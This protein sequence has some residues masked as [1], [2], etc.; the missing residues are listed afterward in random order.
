MKKFILLSVCMISLLSCEKEKNTNDLAS[1]LIISVD[2]AT[3]I[4]YYDARLHGELK[5]LG[6]TEVYDYGLVW[7]E[8]AEPKTEGP[9][10]VYF[11]PATGD[12]T[13]ETTIS[14]LKPATTYYFR[15]FYISGSGIQYSQELSLVTSQMPWTK[16]SDFGG[17]A[18]MWAVAFSIGEKGYFGLGQGEGNVFL[19]DFY[20]YDMKT[21]AWTRKSD[22]PGGPR[23][24]AVGFSI[25]NKGFVGT[26]LNSDYLGTSDFWEYDPAI[27]KWTQKADYIG[28]TIE[29]ATGFSI[30][31]KGYIGIGTRRSIGK[32]VSEFYEYNAA[33]DSWSK[34]TDF[35][36]TAVDKTFNLVINNKG[37][38]GI[39]ETPL[40]YSD[41]F[42]QYD[43]SIN[44][45]SRKNDFPGNASCY[46]TGFSIKKTGYVC[47]GRYGENEVWEYDY[48]SDK[49]N[50]SVYFPG[51]SRHCAASFIINDVAYLGTGSTGF[52]YLKDFWTFSP[53][54]K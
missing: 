49:W 28:G 9:N 15:S 25:G 36:G 24:N 30:E 35:P 29:F 27:D 6:S 37:Y 43:P 5:D 32:R 48:L 44:Q 42:W 16:K 14:N 19:N 47:F 40:G 52:L 50:K 11:G 2:A 20:E 33:T 23:I 46:A 10:K 4:G 39:G 26:G 41:E 3:N 17:A 34:K 1:T 51:Q 53:G 21:S 13:F 12:C 7:S 38:I 8:S 54:N 18:R 22:F 45:W 31:D